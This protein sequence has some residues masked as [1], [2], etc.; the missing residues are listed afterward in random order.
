MEQNSKVQKMS[1]YFPLELLEKVRESAKRN[2]RSFNREVLWQ[3]SQNL[4]YQ[5]SM[6]AA[7]RAQS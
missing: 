4:E 7:A 1:V 6:P 3:L 5:V 2:Q